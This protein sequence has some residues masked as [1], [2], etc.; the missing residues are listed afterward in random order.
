VFWPF[1]EAFERGDL[2]LPKDD[3]PVAELSALHYEFSPTGQVR[4]E[5]KDNAKKRLGR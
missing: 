1:G 4:I 5:P 3:G 2:S